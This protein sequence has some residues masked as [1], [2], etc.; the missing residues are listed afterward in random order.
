LLERVLDG[1]RGAEKVVRSY[2]TAERT[3][4][5]DGKPSKGALR[6]ERCFLAVH[7]IN[8]QLV[9]FSHQGALSRT[10]LELTEHFDVLAVPGLLPGKEVEVGASWKVDNASAAQLCD[11]EGLAEHKLT[12]KLEEVKDNRARVSVIGSAGGVGGGAAVKLV[13]NAS[14]EFDLEAKR[15]V[16][17]EWRQNDQRDQGPISPALS[18]D[19]VIQLK[20]AIIPEPVELSETVIAP[21]KEYDAPPVRLTNIAYRHPTKRFELEH[22]RAWHVVSPDGDERLVLRLMERGQFVAQATLTPWKKT[23]PKQPVTLDEFADLMSK[24]PGWQEEKVIEKIELKDAPEGQRIYRVIATGNLDTVDSVLS[25]YL[26]ISKE[27]EQVIV[28]FS[29]RPN[30]AP[31]LRERDVE[32][33][34][35]IS[36]PEDAGSK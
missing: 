16:A 3:I 32:L 36:F 4:I 13:V 8:D 24:T 23:D 28:T 6:R 11:L 34:K 15:I 29:M 25:F 10:E 31:N 30:L 2:A 26:L 17:V 19:V 21:V 22:A 1:A 20:R 27:G 9:P 14:Y 7:R 35:N 5:F 12:C 33:V 18:A